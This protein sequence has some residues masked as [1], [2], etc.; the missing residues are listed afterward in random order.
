M[1]R[2]F[3]KKNDELRTPRHSLTTT[4][5]AW[6]G[7]AQ[8]VEPRA[9]THR[10]IRMSGTN[11]K[12]SRTYLQTKPA[13]EAEARRVHSVRHGMHQAEAC[14]VVHDTT[15]P[16]V[17][18]VSERIYSCYDTTAST[19]VDKGLSI[20]DSCDRIIFIDIFKP[21]FVTFC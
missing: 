14:S 7:R 1:R 8:S 5:T 16:T 4:T 10:L 18:R 19:D 21:F 3:K 20:L 11:T 9:K 12:Q 2:F 6:T 13:K 17:R 15:G